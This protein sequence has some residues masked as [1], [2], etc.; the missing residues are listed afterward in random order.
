MNSDE[1]IGYPVQAEREIPFIF[2]MMWWLT[3]HV[4]KMVFSYLITSTTACDKDYK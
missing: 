2:N 1:I 4:R 3:E